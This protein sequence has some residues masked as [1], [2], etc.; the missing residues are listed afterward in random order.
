MSQA[1]TPPRAFGKVRH[2]RHAFSAA[3]QHDVRATEHDFFRAEN[4]GAQSRAACLIH[5]ECRRGFRDTGAKSDLTPNVWPTA[6]L[7]RAAPDGILD[8]VGLNFGAS[9]T[10]FGD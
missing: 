8:L 1:R 3:G 9:Q 10:L 6:G 7:A 5:R 2:A 4:N